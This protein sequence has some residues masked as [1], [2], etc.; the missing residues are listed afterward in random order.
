[1]TR[2]WLHFVAESVRAVQTEEEI[3]PA[4]YLVNSREE[5]CHVEHSQRRRQLLA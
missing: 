2:K 3:A 1:M 4:A 5:E